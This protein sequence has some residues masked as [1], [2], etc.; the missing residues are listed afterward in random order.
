LKW[1]W[2][3]ELVYLFYAGH[4][5]SNKYIPEYSNQLIENK[6]LFTEITEY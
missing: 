2:I 3:C 5:F 1:E 4:T 6:Q